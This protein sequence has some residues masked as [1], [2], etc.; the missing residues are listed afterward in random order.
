MKT[1]IETMGSGRWER[2]RNNNYGDGKG[3]REKPYLEPPMITTQE[4]EAGRNH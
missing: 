2:K 3:E 1:M 4:E